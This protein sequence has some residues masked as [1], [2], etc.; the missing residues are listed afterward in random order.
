MR[1]KTAKG[2][3]WVFVPRRHAMVAVLHKTLFEEGTEVTHRTGGCLCGK[4]QRVPGGYRV[5]GRFPFASGRY[6]CEWA[7]LGCTVFTDGAQHFDPNGVPE[8]RQCFLR[9]LQC[10]ILDTYTSG[11][12][13]AGSND[14]VVRETSFGSWKLKV[15]SSGT[16]MRDGRRQPRPEKPSSPRAR[17]RFTD[18]Q[19]GRTKWTRK[20]LQAII[21]TPNQALTRLAAATLRS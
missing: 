12:C 15:C 19:T 9:L 1:P 16:N 2:H 4:P 7:W 5:R 11:L 3:R 6:H 21:V 10:D 14:L 8:T 20:S 17:C 13:G 18:A